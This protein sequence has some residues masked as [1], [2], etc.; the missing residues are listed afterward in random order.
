MQN[1]KAESVIDEQRH[2]YVKTSK[3]EKR[4]ANEQATKK[5][6]RLRNKLI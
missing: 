1:E 6:M 4:H 5:L 2:G 3:T